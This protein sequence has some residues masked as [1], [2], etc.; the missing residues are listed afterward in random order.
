MLKFAFLGVYTYTLYHREHDNSN[1]K[2]DNPNHEH[3]NHGNH[4]HECDNHHHEH[5]DHEDNEMITN[6]TMTTTT[7]IMPRDSG[8]A[9]T[10]GR[11]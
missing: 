11:R 6:M 4:H 2:H 1:H 10:H 7:M 3:D 9:P 5:D 8:N